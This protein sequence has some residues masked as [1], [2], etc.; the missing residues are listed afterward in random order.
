MPSLVSIP[1]S[2]VTDFFVWLHA[3]VCVLPYLFHV[4]S[5]PHGR[6]VVLGKRFAHGMRLMNESCQTVQPQSATETAIVDY[7]FEFES[8]QAK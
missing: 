5:M 1:T 2:S 8:H 4:S 7:S 6:M 3:H